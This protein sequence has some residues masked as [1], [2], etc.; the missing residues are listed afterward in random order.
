MDAEVN[1]LITVGALNK[2]K[3]TEDLVY[4]Y[5]KYVSIY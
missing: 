4:K 5:Y 2:L 3:E 1:K